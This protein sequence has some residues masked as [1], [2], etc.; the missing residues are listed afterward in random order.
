MKE[1]APKE[2]IYTKIGNLYLFNNESKEVENGNRV[3]FYV[4][5]KE[6]QDS[7]NKV[8]KIPYNGKDSKDNLIRFT[9]IRYLTSKNLPKDSLGCSKLTIEDIRAIE[10]GIPNYL[11]L[12]KWS[13]YPY[14]YSFL[15][16]YYSNRYLGY[17]NGSSVFQRVEYLRT[18]SKIIKEHFWFGVGTG[19]VKKAFDKKYTEMN[20]PLE[21]NFRLRAHNQLVTFLLTFGIFGFV[22]ILIALIYPYFKSINGDKFLQLIFL[23]IM[24]I[25][26]FNE[27]TLETQAGLTFVVFFY[28]LFSIGKEKRMPE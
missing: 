16:D 6:L 1:K 14:V 4:E 13:L 5:E 21:Q 2:Y 3:W 15:W 7:W 23:G 19:N 27:D 11:Y 22:W 26:F 10:K 12:N 9:L 25:S 8:S 17:I 24:L 18:A 20:S 28:I